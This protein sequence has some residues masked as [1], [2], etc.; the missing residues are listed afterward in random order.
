MFENSCGI[1]QLGCSSVNGEQIGSAIRNLMTSADESIDTEKA[2]KALDNVRVKY[3]HKNKK[4]GLIYS[5]SLSEE[6]LSQKYAKAVEDSCETE[7]LEGDIKKLDDMIKDVSV[8]Q[9]I[10]DELSSKITLRSAIKLFDKLHEL[11][12]DKKKVESRISEIKEKTLS[13]G[14]ALDRG[15]V[16][17]LNG[18]TN[19]LVGASSFYN[20]LEKLENDNNLNLANKLLDDVNEEQKIRK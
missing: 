13:C 17:I 20:A 5:L 3:L 8:K 1:S 19:E 14:G 7:R 11:E 15:F 4:G 6:E 18:A 10:A 16:A 2:I 12:Q 9:Q